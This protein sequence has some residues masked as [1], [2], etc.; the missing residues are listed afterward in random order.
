MHET[1]YLCYIEEVN[2][3]SYDYCDESNSEYPCA[4]NKSYYGRGPLQLT[5]NYNY[6]AAG[7]AIGFDGLNNPEIVASDP[8]VSFKTALWS[9]MTNVHS[10]ITSGRGFGATIQ[11]INVA[12]CNGGNP[13]SANA[14]VGYYIDYCKQ[15]GV[16][17]GDNLDC[18][19][20][21]GSRLDHNGVRYFSLVCPW[22]GLGFQVHVINPLGHQVYACCKLNHALNRVGWD[23]VVKLSLCM[24]ERWWWRWWRPQWSGG[25]DSGGDGGGSGG[26]SDGGRQVVS[27]SFL[28]FLS[29]ENN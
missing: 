26:V 5:W 14:R 29:S 25:G 16:A 3:A 4:P 21:N 6:G 27:S 18:N 23:E 12:E 15:L 13:A 9:W 17:P 19:G 1:G 24:V 10:I 28:F 8:V 7:A 22:F 2:G 20:D 11:A